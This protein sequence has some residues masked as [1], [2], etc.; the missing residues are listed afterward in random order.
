MSTALDEAESTKLESPSGFTCL[1]Q[2]QSNRIIAADGHF[3][4]AVAVRD[5]GSL[6]EP[7]ASYKTASPGCRAGQAAQ[8]HDRRDAPADSRMWTS[9]AG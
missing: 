1:R 2:A 7:K 4:A 3:S 8:T 5:A 9:P 6:F